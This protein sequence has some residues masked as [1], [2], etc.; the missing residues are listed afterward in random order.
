MKN[1]VV[2]KLLLAVIMIFGLMSCEDRDIITIENQSAPIVMDLSAENLLLDQNFPQNPALTVSWERATF[3]VPVEVKYHVEISSTASFADPYLLAQ[4]AQ[5]VTNVSFTTQEMNEA[6]KRIGL[7]PFESQKMYFRVTSYLGDNDMQQQSKI[8][9]INITPYLASPTY[10]FVDLYLIGDATAGGWDNLA[11]NF[12]LM[13]LLKTADGSKY[14]FTGLFKAGGFKMIK[15]KGSWVAQYGLGAAA[16]QL[17]TDGGSGDIKVL[18]EGYYKL[19]VD[20]SALTYTFEP[21]TAP[22]TTYTSVSIIG[23]V[24]GNWDTDTQLT[25]STFDPHVWTKPG[26]S[27]SAGEFKFRANNAWDTSWGTNSEFF[28]TATINGANI[29]LSAEWTYDVYF[30]DATGAYTLIPVK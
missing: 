23:S 24:N 21:V 28:G 29:P 25:Q 2:N 15:E 12:N 1:I 6:A 22:T 14:T 4:T 3:T 9:S 13:P 30:N 17:S 19:T 10:D 5:S 27:L 18:T 26:V 16:G 8:T 7:V 11:T 20:T